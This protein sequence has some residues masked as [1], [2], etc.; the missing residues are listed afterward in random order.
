MVHEGVT[1]AVGGRWRE[2]EDENSEL[3]SKL[4]ASEQQLAV[5][6]DMVVNVSDQLSVATSEMDSLREEN[7]SKADQLLSLKESLRISYAEIAEMKTQTEMSS[8]IIFDMNSQQDASSEMIE[9]LRVALEEKLH[10]AS[11]FKTQLASKEQA[12]ALQ[13]S[14][15][16]KAEAKNDLFHTELCT[17][18]SRIA[19]QSTHVQLLLRDKERLWSQLSRYRD[20]KKENGDVS[21]QDNTEV[22]LLQNAKLQQ[23]R[24]KSL[25]RSC[26]VS[27]PCHTSNTSMAEL[28]KKL[29]HTQKV[30]GPGCVERIGMPDEQSLFAKLWEF[31]CLVGLHQCQG[32]RRLS[33]CHHFLPEVNG[34]FAHPLKSRLLGLVT[35]EGTKHLIFLLE[36]TLPAVQ[37]C[38]KN[39]VAC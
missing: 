31:G 35:C 17:L 3:R 10:E 23:N 12:L 37:I 25:K 1:I 4:A 5:H 15:K 7:T 18:E 13:S 34:A 30:P 38:L 20:G 39:T 14:L 32:L 26:K 11:Q 8:S 6:K 33:F 19:K 21:K 22:L 24:S 2:I 28:E 36:K 29:W 27:D 16:K 9:N